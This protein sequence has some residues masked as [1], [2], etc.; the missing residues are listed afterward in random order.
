MAKRARK[1]FDGGTLKTTRR[2]SPS[3]LKPSVTPDQLKRVRIGGKVRFVSRE[4]ERVTRRTA[5]ISERQFRKKETGLSNERAAEARAHGGLEYKTAQARETAAKVGDT[6]VKRQI[7]KSL[8]ERVPTNNPRRRKG[9]GFSLTAER[10]ERIE[11]NR[12]RKL[13]GEYIPDGEWQ[14]MV[15]T[16]AK[17]KDARLPILRL[18]PKAS[19]TVGK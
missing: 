9:R 10:V 19:Y 12:E 8:G 17:F 2:S 16:A 15:D 11:R 5:S 4:V 13:Q 18:S 14:E 1:V 3:L 6:R 7:Q